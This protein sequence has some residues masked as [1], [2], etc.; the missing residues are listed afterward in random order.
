MEDC[1]EVPCGCDGGETASRGDVNMVAIRV[2]ITGL[3]LEEATSLQHNVKY[4][5]DITAGNKYIF[6]K[7]MVKIC[8][9]T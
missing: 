2:L 5:V 1:T 7:A 8:M 6:K 4:W 9:F 3:P